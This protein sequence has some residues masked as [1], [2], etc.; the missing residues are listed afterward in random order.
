[1]P[2]YFFPADSDQTQWK[3]EQTCTVGLLYGVYTNDGKLRLLV[4][5]S[6]YEFTTNNSVIVICYSLSILSVT[7]K[8]RVDVHIHFQTGSTIEN[9]GNK[10]ITKSIRDYFHTWFVYSKF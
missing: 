5:N 3:Y 8:Q 9:T 7:Y 4:A 6:Y 1:M 10:R 2:R